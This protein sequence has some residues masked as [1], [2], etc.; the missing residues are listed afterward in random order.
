MPSHLKEK[1][2]WS[3]HPGTCRRQH[4]QKMIALVGPSSL[5]N[6]DGARRFLLPQS[7]LI[8][9]LEGDDPSQQIE[10]Y[11]QRVLFSHCCVIHA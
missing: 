9:E 2:L 10:A 8:H 3:D 11:I 1:R 5:I 4:D 6:G 7:H